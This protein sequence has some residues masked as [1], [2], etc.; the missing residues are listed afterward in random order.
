MSVEIVPGN[1]ALLP[2]FRECLDVVAREKRFLALVEAPPLEAVRNF[3]M[4]NWANGGVQ[5][6]ALDGERV[7]GWADVIPYGMPTIRHRANLGIG[8]LP[9]HRG[10]GL[11]RQLL[12]ATI[13]EALLKRI[14]RIELEVRMDNA[15]AIRLYEKCGFEHECVK[16]GAMKFDD[17]FYDC[18]VMSLVRI[19]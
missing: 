13:R 18:A 8:V 9:E 16:R 1:E 15:N 5:F 7:V 2:S 3:H 10:R 14:F 17:R 12:E 6:F 4:G 11:G 19:P